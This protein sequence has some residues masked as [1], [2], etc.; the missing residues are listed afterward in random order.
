MSQLER[1]AKALGG[2]VFDNGRRA[3]V[4]GPGHGAGDR[5][6]SLIETEEGRILIYCFSPRD[7]W[8]AVRD[9]LRAH[10]LLNASAEPCEAPNA[11]TS[12]TLVVQPQAEDRLMRARRW[13]EE[14]RSLSGTAA[15]AYLRGRHIGVGLASKAM[16]FHPR[17][18]SLDDRQRRPALLAAIHDV[19]GGV[20]GVQAT[21]LSAHGSGK[22]VVATP[23]RVIG[24]LLGGAVRLFPAEE[25]LLIG[26]GVESALSAAEA[27][28]LP[29][30]AALS[31]HNLSLFAP[32]RSVTHLVVAPDNDAAGVKACEILR[33]RLAPALKV[34]QA[35]PPEG[36]NDWN[37]WARAHRD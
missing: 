26:E 13:W 24:R 37:D 10:G 32:P 23:R 5:S 6:V 9:D 22:A 35:L 4:R 27:L 36:L 29:A 17:V 34:E 1:I 16:R 31:A 25:T 15:G 11:Q 33:Q 3:L 28:K 20:Q 19:D 8:R 18:T 14:G 7:D 12:R 30:W 21:L 2:V